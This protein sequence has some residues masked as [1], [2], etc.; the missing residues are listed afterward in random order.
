MKLGEGKR[1]KGMKKKDNIEKKIEKKEN[2]MK[3]K[4]YEE[5][6]DIVGKNRKRKR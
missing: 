1:V 2:E 4:K 3:S 5:K 6:R